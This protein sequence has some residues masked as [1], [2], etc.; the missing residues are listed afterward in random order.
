[1]VGPV[2]GGL[3]R[4]RSRRVLGDV[5]DDHVSDNLVDDGALVV[6]LL[7]NWGAHG[8][9]HEKGRNKG[10]RTHLDDCES[11]CEI[12]TFVCY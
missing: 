12:G 4:G 1:M 2:I 7:V 6:Q 8:A 9:S 5:F 3:H 10:G 11:E